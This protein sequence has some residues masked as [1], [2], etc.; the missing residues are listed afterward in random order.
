MIKRAEIAERF[1]ISPLVTDE[2]LSKVAFLDLWNSVK[3][4]NANN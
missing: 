3:T 1:F 2:A 4:S